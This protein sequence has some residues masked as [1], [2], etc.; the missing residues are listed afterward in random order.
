MKLSLWQKFKLY[1]L[2][3]D[4]IMIEK[5]KSRKMWAVVITA[6]LVTLGGQLGVSQDIVD[7][8]VRLVIGYVAAQGVADAAANLKK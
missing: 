7:A 3:T 4:P 6:A 1:K 2:A 8:I 5:L